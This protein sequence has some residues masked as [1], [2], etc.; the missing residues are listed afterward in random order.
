[1]FRMFEISI[2][3]VRRRHKKGVIKSTL[4]SEFLSLG[5]IFSSLGFV[6]KHAYKQS[7]KNL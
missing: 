3:M 7:V 6:H 2:G 1:M 5:E 4:L